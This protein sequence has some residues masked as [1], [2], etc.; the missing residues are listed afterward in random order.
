VLLARRHRHADQLSSCRCWTS[1]PVLLAKLIAG[2]TSARTW[3]P[4]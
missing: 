3:T 2:T 4:S 1:G